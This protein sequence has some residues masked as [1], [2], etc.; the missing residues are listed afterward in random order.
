MTGISA[1]LNGVLITTASNGNTQWAGIV[2]ITLWSDV[3]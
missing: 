2:A 3:I 1:A